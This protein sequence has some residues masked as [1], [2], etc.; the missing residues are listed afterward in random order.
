[1]IYSLALVLAVARASDPWS[2]V[3][4]SLVEITA[5]TAANLHASRF[6]SRSWHVRF[7]GER[8]LI[9]P[10]EKRDVDLPFAPEI[11]TAHLGY[12]GTQ[13]SQVLRIGD[14]WF[15][16]YYHGEFGGGLWQFDSTGTVGRR[17]ID[18]PTYGLMFYRGELLA[19][20]QDN[21]MM[22]RRVRIHRFALQHGTWQEV[23]HTDFPRNIGSVKP[24]GSQLYAIAADYPSAVLAKIDLAGNLTPVWQFNRDLRVA[25]IARSPKGDFAIGGQGYVVRLHRA[26]DQFVATWYAPRDCVSYSNVEENDGSTARCVAMTGVRNYE[27]HRR[28]PVRNPLISR[29]G[30]WILTRY[31]PIQLLHFTGSQWLPADL[32]SF[33][34]TE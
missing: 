30:N 23:A 3:A 9:A 26:G 20:T 22:V 15:L 19:E 4:K 17:L 25:D 21:S 1:M 18:D 2:S 32:P 6:A 33:S 24:L 14:A 31:L 11:D 28:V 7:H 29:D 16:A 8:L 10:I 13:P 27:A 5:P 12:Y 34:S